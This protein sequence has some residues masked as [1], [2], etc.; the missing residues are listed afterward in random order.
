MKNKKLLIIILCLVL[1]VTLLSGC[2]KSGDKAA[3]DKTP[4]VIGVDLDV[5]GAGS[6]LGVPERDSIKMLAEDLNSNG[7][8]NGH[9]IKLVEADNESDETKA[10]LTGR[11]LITQDNVLAIIGTAQS[12]TSVPISEVAEREGIPSIGM[13]SSDAIVKGKKWAFKGPTSSDLLFKELLKG[14][15]K[16]GVKKL[17]FISV[18]NAYGDSGLGAFDLVVKDTKITPIYKTKFSADT[19]DMSVEFL[20]AK[21]AGADGILVWAVMPGI[22]VANRDFARL[23]LQDQGM[24]LFSNSTM[25][26][27]V[28]L[29]A[30]GKEAAKVGT[31][32]LN[33]KMM[34]AEQLSSD[35]PSKKV[36]DTFNN[37]YEKK[38]KVG[39]RVTYAAN[40]H[41][42]F[43]VVV[44]AIKSSNI[45]PDGDLKKNREAIREAMEKT[46][47]LGILGNYKFSATNHRGSDTVGY[48]ISK[49]VI[50][51]DGKPTFAIVK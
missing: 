26:D 29:D 45:K 9:P 38:Y 1:A 8:I 51:S 40:A 25:G 16:A 24:M 37:L 21:K 35:D 13:G 39:K 43:N 20:N 31:Q 15:E 7:G 28:F 49:V 32:F 19:T 48:I 44:N 2:G 33:Y 34:I 11:K 36:I 22:G 4:F 14:I 47:F 6:A 10:R 27:P 23:G 5:T 46:D 3:T 41:D 17:A 30:A 18:N 42:S 50:G 12:T